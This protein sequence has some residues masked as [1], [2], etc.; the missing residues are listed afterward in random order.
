MKRKRFRITCLIVFVF[1]LSYCGYNMVYAT[2]SK[3]SNVDDDQETSQN[4]DEQI[5]YE[6]FEALGLYHTTAV[7]PDVITMIDGSWEILDNGQR[8][9]IHNDN[10]DTVNGWQYIDGHW[11]FFDM[12]GIMYTGWLEDNGHI[13]YLSEDSSTIGQMP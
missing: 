9:F 2:D 8:K 10:R 4:S 5:D 7:F 11:Y 6:F 12:N 3:T 1:V 13:Y